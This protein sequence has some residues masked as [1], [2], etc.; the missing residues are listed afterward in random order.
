V[1]G[2]K[3][4]LDIE[5]LQGCGAVD[6][7]P[8]DVDSNASDAGKGLAVGGSKCVKCSGGDFGSAVTA[9][10]SAVEEEAD[11]GDKKGAC[12]DERAE[13]VVNGV[14]LESED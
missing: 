13:E 4:E 5:A 12:Y 10:E 9:I 11:F 6:E 1:S 3:G 2:V 8:V 7:G 14:G